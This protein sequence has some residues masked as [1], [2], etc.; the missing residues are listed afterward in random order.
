M[1]P[2][3]RRRRCSR[4]LTP[5]VGLQVHALPA[6]GLLHQCNFLTTLHEIAVRAEWGEEELSK[7]G[8]HTVQRIGSMERYFGSQSLASPPADLPGEPVPYSG[9][10]YSATL[11]MSYV[12][13][14]TAAPKVSIEGPY[15]GSNADA[16]GLPHA[17][18]EVT[19]LCS[20]G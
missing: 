17:K 14:T 12:S 13:I 10:V 1:I 7:A 3:A 15:A 16:P 5:A 9:R 6:L 11:P 19:V 4:A 20:R 18:A 8:V 2:K